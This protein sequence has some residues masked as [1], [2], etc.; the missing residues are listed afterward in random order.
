MI[1]LST[2]YLG[3]RLA[4]PLVV[5]ASP[6]SEDLGNIRRMEDAGAGAVVMHS[7]FEEQIEIQSED[8]HRFLEHGT[9]VFAESLT[10]FP[11]QTKFRLGPDEYVEHIARA[12]AAVKVP[13]IGSLNGVTTG[14]W[15]DYAAMIE[16]AGADALELNVYQVPADPDVPGSMV[17]HGII[18]LV[19]EVKAR[20]RIPVAVKLSPFFSAP[21]HLARRL[22]GAAADGL[23]IFNRFYQPDFDLDALE[24][25]P[26]L[27]LSRTN[28]LPLRLHWAAILYGRIQADIAITGGV[29]SAACVLKC[30][31]AGASA[32]MMT[33]ALLA[34]GIGHLT[35]VRDDLVRWMTEREYQ[36]VRQMKGSMSQKKVADPSMFE[37]GNY[38]KVLRGYS[39]RAVAGEAR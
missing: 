28:E 15:L 36:S 4:N 19:R 38:M 14:G 32:A 16:Q 30:L 12:K 10:Y 2:D 25:V 11:D 22:D 33:S 39:M 9:H 1:D 8:L 5:S 35:A 27:Q 29:H 13:I 26:H 34:H 6:L 31:M 7:L 23:V 20:V 18:E 24:V 3:L 17:E 21:L 37:R